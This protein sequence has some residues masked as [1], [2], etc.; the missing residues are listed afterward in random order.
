MWPKSSVMLA[1]MWDNTCF[2]FVADIE[3][4]PRC[5]TIAIFLGFADVILN[6]QTSAATVTILKIKGKNISI[7]MI[8]TQLSQ[9]NSQWIRDRQGGDFE[10]TGNLETWRDQC[11]PKFS[12]EGRG[13]AVSHKSR[14]V[15]EV[16]CLFDSSTSLLTPEMKGDT[17]RVILMNT[18]THRTRMLLCS[19]SGC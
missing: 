13:G 5:S 1:S 12:G 14:G 15:K 8:L 11:I 6:L 9:N 10:G 4:Q 16:I 19:P 18:T 7:S 3:Q 17:G 2:S